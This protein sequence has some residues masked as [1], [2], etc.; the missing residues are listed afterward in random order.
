MKIFFRLPI[1]FLFLSCNKSKNDTLALSDDLTR[2]MNIIIEEYE[3]FSSNDEKYL[4]PSIYEVH[5]EEIE[6][7]CFL[8]IA[9]NYFYR[10]DM[11]AFDTTDNNLIAYYNLKSKCNTLVSGKPKLDSLILKRFLN[12]NDAFDN[13]SPAVWRFQI[14]EN[15]LVPV[16]QNRLQLNFN[17]N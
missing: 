7:T 6:D 12:E 2:A 3:S 14:K 15:I 5:F 10:D 8:T 17:Q 1:L 16:Y 9:T 11:D 13:Y 4:N